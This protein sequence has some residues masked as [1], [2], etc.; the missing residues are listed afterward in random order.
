MKINKE[1]NPKNTCTL[2]EWLNF[3]FNVNRF[4]ELHKEETKLKYG[5]VQILKQSEKIK[6]EFTDHQQDEVYN[7]SVIQEMHCAVQHSRT[8]V[9]GSSDTD[10]P[11]VQMKDDK[12]NCIY[13]NEGKVQMMGEVRKLQKKGI[14]ERTLMLEKDI[15]YTPYWVDC[16][17]EA[18]GFEL[19]PTFAE[20]FKG[21][22]IDN[23]GAI[24]NKAEIPTTEQAAKESLVN[25]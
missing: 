23:Q 10:S 2:L 3:E 21:F 4:L 17:K 13:T 7:V 9:D 8:K 24:W 22:V 5:L 14:E 19:E 11:K 1:N 15:E 16:S 6:K 25:E 12:G 20:H 18:L